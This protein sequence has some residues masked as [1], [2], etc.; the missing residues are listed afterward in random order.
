MKLLFT[1]FTV[2]TAICFNSS[3]LFAETDNKAESKEVPSH[4]EFRVKCE[5]KK[6]M[7]ACVD[8]AIAYMMDDKDY[9]NALKYLKIACD[10]KSM[11][12]CGMQGHLYQEG[13]GVKQDYKIAVKLYKQSCDGG[14]IPGCGALADMYAKGNGIKQ[15]SD[16]ALELYKKACDK[17]IKRGCSSF[18]TLYDKECSTDPKKFCK[19]YKK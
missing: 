13:L 2:V 19:K 9:S 7:E 6:D 3:T 15:D 18:K 14:E 4:E 11:I 8:L 5:D 17:D 10:G 1:M 12:G 16:K